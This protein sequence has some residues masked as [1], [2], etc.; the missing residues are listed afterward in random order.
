M[1][2][3]LFIVFILLLEVYSFQLI[4]TLSKGHWWKWVYLGISILVVAN[5]F[6]QFY[7]YP[8]RAVV[9]GARD[10]SVTLL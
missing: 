6:L 7:L 5:V 3:F 2:L 10:L 8:N 9:S 1:R 4:R